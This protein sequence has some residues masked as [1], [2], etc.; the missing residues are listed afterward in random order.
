MLRRFGVISALTVALFLSG[1]GCKKSPTEGSFGLSSIFAAE[2][3]ACQKEKK[4]CK[5]DHCTGK[6]DKCPCKG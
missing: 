4:D 2:E 1:S 6:S 3:C 5:C